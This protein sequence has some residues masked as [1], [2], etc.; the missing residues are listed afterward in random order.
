MAGL[1]AFAEVSVARDLALVAVV[2]DRYGADPAAFCRVVRALEGI[3]LRLVSQ[4]DARRNVTLVIDEDDL[5]LAMDRLHAEFFRPQRAGGS[6]AAAEAGRRS[7][8][9]RLTWT[10]DNSRF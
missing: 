4:A 6:L 2:G 5:S 9:E 1:S 7:E 10:C 3:P 8:A